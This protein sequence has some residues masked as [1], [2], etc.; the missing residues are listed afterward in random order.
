MSKERVLPGVCL[1]VSV[2]AV[3]LAMSAVQRADTLAEELRSNAGRVGAARFQAEV[4]A[5]GEGPAYA[6]GDQMNSFAR[7]FAGLWFAVHSENTELAEYELHEMHEVIEGI[8]PL[9]KVENGV[10]INGVLEGLEN[11]Q[12]KALGDAIESKDL[13]AF[14]KAYHETMRACNDCH[15]SAGHGFIRIRVPTRPP[16]ANRDY[17][18]LEDLPPLAPLAPLATTE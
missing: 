7:R 4:D 6:F 14:E 8:E 17:R 9:H 1:V 15:T 10:K 11:G 12:L 16:V 18:P 5:A 13:V 3:A 2:F